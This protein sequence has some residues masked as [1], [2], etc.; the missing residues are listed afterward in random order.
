MKQE[1]YGQE[2]VTDVFESFD[3]YGAKPIKY[4]FNVSKL[5]DKQLGDDFSKVPVKIQIDFAT[6]FTDEKLQ[7]LVTRY[8]VLNRIVEVFTQDDAGAT[9]LVGQF[10]LDVLDM[11]W[12][13]IDVISEH[14]F[15]LRTLIEVCSANTLKKLFPLQK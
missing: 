15:A 6:D 7:D 9:N 2:F 13:L 8:S 11:D 10:R 4:V 1:F 14:P 3:K 5:S 12:D